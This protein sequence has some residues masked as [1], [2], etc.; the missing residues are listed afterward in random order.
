MIRVLI[1]EDMHMVRGALVALMSLESDLDVVA[2]VESGTAILPA[3]RRT[4]PDVAVLDINLPGIDGLAAAAKLRDELPGCRTVLLTAHASG[5]TLARAMLV[6]VCGFL[7]KGAP[8]ARLAD[9]IRRV[10]LGERVI[11]PDVVVDAFQHGPNPLTDRERDVLACVAAGHDVSEV[12]AQL[13][14]ATGTVRNYLSAIMVKIGARNRVD[15]VR[16]AT[17]HGWLT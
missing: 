12:A 14:L 10:H 5:G 13:Y 1:A 3:A 17:D 4:K 16:I 9:A 7:P 15:A 11:D 8:P 6:Q 2:D